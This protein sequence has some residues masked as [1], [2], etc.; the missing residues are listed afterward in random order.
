MGGVR[1]GV[2]GCGTIS[3]LAY[4][5]AIK[6]EY[7]GYPLELV[8]VCDAV[9]EKA[10][11]AA[12]RFGARRHYAR[13]EDLLADPEVDAVI[14]ATNIATHAELGLAA[15]RAGK[16]VLIQKPIA[17]TLEEADRI[18]EEARRRGVKLQ[19]EPPHMLNPFC[20]RSR[21]LI[22]S[23][24]LGQVCLVQASSSHAGAE[25]RPWLFQRA[26]G[27]SVMLDLAVHALTWL[28]GLLGPV[29]Q[30]TAMATTS[31]PERVINGEP[32]KVDIEDNVTILLRFRDGCLGTVVSNYVTIAN[33]APTINIYGTD[34][35]IH[36]ESG[37]SPFL[38]FSRKGKYLEHDGWLEPTVYAGHLARPLTVQRATPSGELPPHNSVAHFVECIV[39]DK[40]PVPSGE[41]ARHV[42][43][44]MLAAMESA[45]SGRTI[46]LQTSF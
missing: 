45:R 14:V 10:V 13:Y 42:L 31:V 35:T 17:E 18:I 22:S 5:P 12:K 29:A 1:F 28:T 2:I 39:E 36:L 15:V 32:V 26:G 43:E 23:G 40:Q 4:L 11:S 25:D 44:I 46:E 16:H 3:T 38:L 7:A 30:V 33:K 9:E 20:V 21:E 27:G 19:V 6:G 8:A 34:G 41:F 24:A 37:M